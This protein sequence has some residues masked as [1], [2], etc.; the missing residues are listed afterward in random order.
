[1]LYVD[2]L[3]ILTSVGWAKHYVI[4]IYNDNNFIVHIDIMVQDKWQ[5]ISLVLNDLY[6]W[7]FVAGPI[8]TGVYVCLYSS[9]L[10][11]ILHVLIA[12]VN[13]FLDF[14]DFKQ[15]T[16]CCYS[17]LFISFF[18]SFGEL[19]SPFVRY[20]HC[21]PVPG[22]RLISWKHLFSGGH[23]SAAVCVL[24]PGGGRS[25]SVITLSTIFYL[26]ITDH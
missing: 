14:M 25:R 4:F 9:T 20:V 15:F 10:Y 17:V 7:P 3:G 5:T 8:W 23:T 26:L 19:S 1:M 24:M 16:S 13:I 6:F 21:T 11:G 22:T 18:F 2:N 12:P